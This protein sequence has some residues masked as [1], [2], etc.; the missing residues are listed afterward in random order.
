MN[1]APA[2]TIEGTTSVATARKRETSRIRAG[3]AR[4]LGGDTD[5]WLG[6][7]S[8]LEEARAVVA[9]LRMAGRWSECCVGQRGKHLAMWNVLNATS[10]SI[11]RRECRHRPRGEPPPGVP[12]S[13]CCAGGGRT[14]SLVV[15]FVQPDWFQP[16]KETC[17]A[18]GSLAC[19][20]PRDRLGRG[21][22]HVVRVC[23]HKHSYSIPYP[24]IM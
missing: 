22:S 17:R 7:L 5:T 24:D 23:R 1:P 13:P 6:E 2:R 8:A 12:F 15:L 10:M 20:L 11:A 9:A 18:P 3:H 14:H 16:V 21:I 19:Q 4:S